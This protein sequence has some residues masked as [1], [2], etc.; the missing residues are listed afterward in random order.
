MKAKQREE[1]KAG[2]LLM[3]VEIVLHRNS[4]T[5]QKLQVFKAIAPE[6][7]EVFRNTPLFNMGL[8]TL[9]AVTEKVSGCLLMN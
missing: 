2:P 8:I 1:L 4:S 3:L 9:S 6:Y 7:A 5:T